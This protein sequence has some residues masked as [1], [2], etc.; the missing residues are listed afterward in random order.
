M[1]HKKERGSFMKDQPV[2]MSFQAFLVGG[3]IGAVTQ[4]F[5]TIYSMFIPDAVMAIYLSLFTLGLLGGLLSA[6]GVFGKLD[7]FSGMGVNVPTFGLG[8]ATTGPIIGGRAEGKPMGKAV[9]EG[10]LVPL[11]LLGIAAV[12]GFVGAVIKYF[13]G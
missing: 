4:G 12:I 13:L 5:L 9:I 7:K 2:R 11:K 8:A 10:L 3:L 1:T 6:V